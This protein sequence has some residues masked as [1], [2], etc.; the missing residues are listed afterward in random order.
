[1]LLLSNRGHTDTVY[2]RDD[3]KITLK[4]FLSGFE[5]S[6]LHAAV[7]AA[8]YQLK[9]DNIEQLIL[10]FPRSDNVKL[11]EQKELDEIWFEKV[12]HTWSEV[13]KLVESNKVVSAG[14]ADF[15]L[16]ALKALY[17]RSTI[18]PCVNHYNIEGCCVV[19]KE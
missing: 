19:S 11:D 10:A 16:P 17:E 9:T 12:V 18:K 8:I 5:I 4:V 2:E 3:L 14:V 1:M 6:Q 7:D 15:E 13:E